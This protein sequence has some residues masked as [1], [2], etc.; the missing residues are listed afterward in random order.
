MCRDVEAKGAR[1]KSDLGARARIAVEAKGARA[2][3]SDLGY[4]SAE[5]QWAKV[6]QRL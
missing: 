6:D 5:G 2:M 3:A 1:A 4:Y